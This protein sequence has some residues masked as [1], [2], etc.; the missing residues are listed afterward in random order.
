M[1]ERHRHTVLPDRV[2]FVVLVFRASDCRRSS[3]RRHS[4]ASQSILAA[5]QS[6]GLA[7][8]YSFYLSAGLRKGVS[9]R[10]SITQKKIEINCRRFRAAVLAMQ[11]IAARARFP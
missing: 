3:M 11:Q 10:R 5:M 7:M 1:L 9:V 4:A 2:D 6:Y 8:T